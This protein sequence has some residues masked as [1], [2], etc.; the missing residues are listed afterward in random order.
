[1]RTFTAILYNSRYYFITAA[2]LLGAS[3]GYGQ[4]TPVVIVGSNAPFCTGAADLLL[5]ETGG[6]AVQWNWSGPNAFVSSIQNPVIPNA[7]IAA[8]GLYAVTI[9]DDDNNTSTAV[10]TVV[11]TPTPVVNPVTDQVRC[12]GTSTAPIFFTG[13]VPGAQFNW[14]NSDGS[15]GLATAGTGDIA[16]FAAQNTNTVPKTA[17]VTVLPQYT[18]NGLTCTGTAD[19]FSFLVQ[20]T[21]VVVV[22]PDLP[23]CAGGSDTLSTTTSGVTCSWAPATGL[24]NA[25]T[26]N[27][28]AS[29]TQ[30]T[31]YTVTVTNIN[32]CTNTDAVAVT[33]HIPKAL[34][35][36]NLVTISLNQQGTAMITPDMILQGGTLDDPL[37]AIKI[38][39]SAGMIVSNP[40]TCAQIGQT[41]TVKVTDICSNL[42]CWGSLKVE[43]KLAPQL[44]CK[45]LMLSCA[46]TTYTPEYLK[47][48]LNI[49]TA[50]AAV[51]ENCG[52]LSLTY[53]DTW[54]DLGCSGSVNGMT[55]LS[56]YALRKWT[57]TDSYGNSA[58]CTQYLYFRRL[59]LSDLTMPP[60][61]VTVDCANPDISPAVTGVPF[62]T[63]FGV[64]FPLYPNTSFCELNAVY[65]DLV[66]QVCDGSFQIKRTWTIYEW[67]V[68]TGPSN[69]LIYI[70]LLKVSDATGPQFVCPANLT[71]STDPFTC[72]AIVDLPDVILIDDCSRSNQIGAVV[73]AYE[74]YTNQPIG[75]YAV[76]G[77]LMDFPGNNLWA[78]DTLGAL[79]PTTCLPPGTHTVTYTAEDDCGNTSSCSFQ[80][81]VDDLSPPVV[82]CDQLTQVALGPTGMVSVDA[83]TFDDGSFDNCAPVRFKVRRMLANG[84]Q[85]ANAFHDQVKFCCSDIGDTV[86]VVLRVYDVPLP[87]GDVAL[88]YE[89]Q[90][91]NS[92]MVQVLVEDK[93]KPVCTPPGNFS[94]TC[95]AFDPTLSLYGFA[96]AT[97]NCCIDTV[98][99]SANLSLFDTVCNRG[100]ITR[101]FRAFD[102]AGLST[103]CTQ[104]IMVEYVQNYFLKLPDDKVVLS[105]DGT[106]NY[107]LPTFF[108]ED[109]ELIGYSYEDQLFTVVPDA[110]YKIE[111]TW[112]IIN[113]CTYNSGDSCIFVPNPEPTT[114]LNSPNNLRAP[115]LSPAGTLGQW[116]PTIVNLTPTS[117]MPTNYSN[118]WNPNANCYI[119][120]QIIKVL[121]T[122]DPVIE[123]PADPVEVCDLSANNP[124]LWND[125]TWYETATG[126]HD[127]C[128]GPTNLNI[129][130]FDSCSGLNVT[131]HYLLFLDL[132]NNGSMETVI[133]SETPP[134][135]GTVNFNNAFNP[136]FQGGQARAFDQRSVPVNDKFRFAVQ[137]GTNPAGTKNVFSL[138]FT[139]NNAPG[140]Y[141]VPELPYGTHKIKWL[142]ED[143]C[144]NEKVC[145]YNFTVKDC[146]APTV[147][148]INGL[149]VNIMPTQMVQLWATDFLQYANDNCTPANQ[150]KYGVRRVGQGTGFPTATNGQPQTNV[151]FTCADLGLQPVELWAMD[152]AGNADYCVTF[153][154]VQ[155]N[156]GNCPTVPAVV[157]GLLATE[158]GEGLEEGKV[159]LTGID[160]ASL[161]INYLE[162]TGNDGQF[163]FNSA[164]PAGS[165][166]TVTPTKD[167]N[168]LNGVSTYD[169][170]LISRHILGLEPITTPYRMIAA[171]ANRSGSITTFDI[172]ELRKL[173]LGIYQELPNNTSWRFVDKTYVFP[174]PANPFAAPFPENKSVFNFQPGASPFDFIAL[175]VGDIN[176]NVLPNSLAAADRST[177]LLLFS[178]EDRLVQAGEIFAVSF[179][180]TEPVLGGQFTLQYPGLEVLELEPGAMMGADNFAVFPGQHALTTAWESAGPAEFTVRFRAQGSGQL[181][182]LLR[183]SSH[184]TR[185][186]AYAVTTADPLEVALQFNQP[187]TPQVAGVGFELYQNEPNPFTGYTS[188]AFHLPAASSATLTV[189][190]AT[191]RVCWTQRDDFAKGYHRVVLDGAALPA[192]GLLYYQLDTP[193]RHAVGKM[194]RL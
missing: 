133:N 180:A 14:V 45:N 5:T 43:D 97:D 131:A 90:H 77:A 150:L 149:S 118:Y 74:Y 183:V 155:D 16:A 70:Q 174:Q 27:P 140:T 127:L 69:P 32:G 177:G 141:T 85:S 175:I 63:A 105:C 36:N 119:Y 4:G 22:G 55:D 143:G 112:T 38:T 50:Y 67:C 21:P 57:A 184:I 91:S 129:T 78:P 84:C 39:T 192:N 42:S 56:S 124:E 142:V 165:N 110:C 111:R 23:I 66:L 193:T 182:Q 41:L 76:G 61:I 59:H 30:N 167:D 3:N 35:C 117:P 44:S 52:L 158:I 187:G 152:L 107:G 113:W 116:T 64:M 7:T 72:C 82:S 159:A 17:V 170:V 99:Q 94:V 29:P 1:M 19:N 100:T 171:D 181:S 109:C 188:I 194:I 93:I 145:E 151:V 153:V 95:E 146:K 9:T 132:D 172:V 26:C 157:S 96:T 160:P 87:A 138:R 53:V 108:G 47:N 25:N 130:A 31:L 148:C 81:K 92:C 178:V 166:I 88:D 126:L 168:P 123:C 179:Q 46:I 120:K 11:I 102:C 163:A 128:E 139:S 169:L 73:D 185:A 12:N 144:G 28:I 115:V 134:A 2:L 121:D 147:V 15:I 189:S 162:L 114:T 89:E 135:A 191:G 176:G 13:N 125:S 34:S 65:T 164:V 137:K 71:V 106:G 190:D 186:E 156:N 83:L 68:S 10:L 62:Y 60:A 161:P 75:S 154:L 101:T 18:A 136:N 104:R 54:V 40:V 24:S 80:L 33:I 86:L 58:T 122:Q 51:Q 79:G 6:E 49:D 37:F 98:T 48:V 20:P 8:A 173:I 103:S